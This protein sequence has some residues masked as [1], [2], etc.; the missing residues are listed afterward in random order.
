MTEENDEAF[1]EAVRTDVAKILE[2]IQKFSPLKSEQGDTEMLGECIVAIGRDP[3]ATPARFSAI[4]E[5]VQEGTEID[6]S[7]LSSAVAAYIPQGIPPNGKAKAGLVCMVC[8]LLTLASV[9]EA[10]GQLSKYNRARCLEAM[11]DA[12]R[13]MGFL[14]GVLQGFN[15]NTT[16]Q[17]ERA[18]QA[19]RATNGRRLIGA[20]TRERVRVAAE[21]HRHLKKG[22][23]AFEIAPKVGLSHDR[24]RK[25][26]SE[27]FPGDSWGISSDL[28]SPNH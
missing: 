8:T 20:S 22:D 7:A 15:M 24:V 12:N 3:N 19:R 2:G 17:D 5:Q 18:E 13:W 26:L 23:A 4:L 21:H 14:L 25:L 6:R 28:T 11:S 1:T 27:L 9:I 10:M 16:L